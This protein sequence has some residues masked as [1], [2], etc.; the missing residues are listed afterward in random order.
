LA[1]TNG[2][3]VIL[4]MYRREGFARW[5]TVRSISGLSDLTASVEARGRELLIRLERGPG[6]EGGVFSTRIP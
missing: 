5:G 1:R 4:S 3:A 6:W 2:K